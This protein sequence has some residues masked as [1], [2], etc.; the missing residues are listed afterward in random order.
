MNGTSVQICCHLFLFLCIHQFYLVR[1][2]S[3][4]VSRPNII[5]LLTDDQD[6]RH[7]S[8]IAM[9]YTA[10]HVGKDGANMT[11]HF[12]NTPICCPSRATLLSGRFEHNNR[13]SGPKESGCM[14]MNTSR[15][16]N[17]M[18]W[19]QSFVHTLHYDYGYVTGLFGKV[20]NN[21]NTYGC[22]GNK[23]IPDGIDRAYYMCG[24]CNFYNQDWF[25]QGKKYSTGKQP[26]NY[27]TSLIGNRSLEW[28]RSVIETGPSH[29]PFFAYLGPHAPHLPATPAPWYLDHPVGNN[30]APQEIYYNYSGTGKHDFIPNEPIIDQD[31]YNSIN[32]EYAKRL[33]SLLSV[34]DIVIALREYLLSVNEWK[35]TYVF[36][37]S[38]H[39]YNLGQFRVDS[40]KTMVYDHNARVPMLIRG[41]SIQRLTEINIISSMADLGPT[42]LELAAGIGEKEVPAYMDGSSFASI[43]SQN[44]D[45]ILWKN[46]TLIEYQ[47]IRTKLVSEKNKHWHD[48]PNNTFSGIRII[49]EEYDLLYAEFADVTDP[50]A[51]T[52]EPDS[53]NFYELY[54]VSSDYYMLNNIYFS[55]SKKLKNELHDRLHQAISCKGH[56]NCT[57]ALSSFNL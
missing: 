18:W 52:F 5:V 16:T 22:K 38:D 40:H 35:N 7:K 39:G 24:G 49:S 1:Y 44:S 11:N 56:Q 43:L 34:D 32:E 33:R 25:D 57:T 17:P 4:V 29:P 10:E 42:I 13:V 55:A 30:K 47:S 36:F 48:G 54:N 3:A 14:R 12:I 27:T 19:E 46:A 50:R 23:S 26:E 20:L 31:D 28:I 8:M 21:M 15:D 41:P 37:S 2:V 45:N 9:P 6:L 53:I 51:W